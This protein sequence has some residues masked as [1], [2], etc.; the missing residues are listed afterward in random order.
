[1]KN[2][3]RLSLETLAKMV[4]VPGLIS[5]HG[6]TRGYVEKH[7]LEV[8][9]RAIKL[10]VHV[11][12]INSVDAMYTVRT[13]DEENIKLAFGVAKKAAFTAN[14]MDFLVTKW[15][16]DFGLTDVVR[17][18]KMNYVGKNVA[19]Q[20]K[21]D[22]TL[23]TAIDMLNISENF[24]AAEM[25]AECIP[26]LHRLIKV[27]K[28]GSFSKQGLDVS[29]C[30]AGIIIEPILGAMVMLGNNG[31]VGCGNL[32]KM[33]VTQ[34][35][36]TQEMFDKVMHQ[37]LILNTQSRPVNF[38]GHYLVK[39][40]ML[41]KYK[42]NLDGIKP[43]NMLVLSMSDV[44]VLTA[45]AFPAI[46]LGKQSTLGFMEPAKSAY[47]YVETVKLNYPNLADRQADGSYLSTED[48]KKFAARQEKLNKDRPVHVSEMD[49]YFL[50]DVPESLANRFN[51]G[52]LYPAESWV[53]RFGVSRIV[54]HVDHGLIKGA[55]SI[56][57][58]VDPIIGKNVGFIATSSYKGKLNGVLRASGMEFALSKDG[59][60]VPNGFWEEL[61]LSDGTVLEVKRCT[62]EVLV[63][64][65][66]AIER[67]YEQTEEE[68]NSTGEADAI[69]MDKVIARNSF[70]YRNNVLSL[71]ILGAIET[72]SDLMTEITYRREQGLVAKGNLTTVTSSEFEVVRNTY[73]RDIALEYMHSLVSNPLNSIESVTDKKSRGLSV[74]TSKY[75]VLKEMGLVD[76]LELLSSV[77]SDHSHILGVGDAYT[78]TNRN[79]LLA[80]IEALGANTDSNKVW[81]KINHNGQSVHIPTGKHLYGSL[82]TSSPTVDKVVV[83]GC[84]G[85]V[86]AALDR[87]AKFSTITDAVATNVILRI[88]FEVQWK[89][90]S[91]N[92]GKLNVV[93][94]Y[95]VLLPGH[96]L[97][98]KYDVCMPS[99]GMYVES[100]A[101][102]VEANIAKHPVLMLESISGC[103]VYGP[104]SMPIEMD[105]ELLLALAP[106]L[107]V[108]PDYLLELQNDADGDQ[109]RVSFDSYI[110]PLY[111]SE[112][113]R[114][115]AKAFHLQY[116]AKEN[117][118]LVSDHQKTKVW[119]GIDL[120]YALQ[121]AFV[122]K[123]RVG[124][125]TDLMHKVAA[126]IDKACFGLVGEDVRR[127]IVMIMGIL[128]QECAMNAIKHNSVDSSVTVADALGAKLLFEVLEEKDK[129]KQFV[130]TQRAI[131]MVTEFFDNNAYSFEDNAAFAKVLVAAVRKVHLHTQDMRMDLARKVFKDAPKDS[132]GF[133]SLNSMYTQQQ[134][135]SVDNSSSMFA[136]LLA[137]FGVQS[138][139]VKEKV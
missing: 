45:I 9:L 122:S 74:L 42:M 132:S 13:E 64:N 17:A 29:L 116:I 95:F 71:D 65:P 70:K 41:K 62:V 136:N 26:T 78:T 118:M 55:T 48:A 119:S 138:G 99:R 100:D 43:G 108:H 24:E 109:A 104:D 88:K 51:T 86:L 90:L 81:I 76:V 33:L 117:D 63:T 52:C 18:M 28:P 72:G 23:L 6:W 49:L 25:L 80:F 61:V 50:R 54:S 19:E 111:T 31:A 110:L 130:G 102:C 5:C 98:N 85:K 129:P 58:L 107:F 127:K 21:R 22:N 114:S 15:N 97:E 79:F 120:H 134:I 139:I 4:Q 89:F 92:F 46:T 2:L 93:G 73:G 47:G 133:I 39:L 67:F 131:T 57:T 94:N 16:R 37:V 77:S 96:W 105:E 66:Y 84:I 124:I 30:S 40:S 34:E 59:I 91:K 82:F 115:E 20:K 3:P 123:V 135:V 126:N 75:N 69:Q 87:A 36:F 137:M 60:N 68:F 35:Y 11:R 101:D 113:L 56:A 106:V 53:R 14:V 128:I 10:E 27:N 38:N 12:T 1:M 112:V 44:G 83:E 8:V 125:Y 121:E 103:H 32:V 7:G